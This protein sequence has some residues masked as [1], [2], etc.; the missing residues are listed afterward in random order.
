MQSLDRI[1]DNLDHVLHAS[2]AD[3]TEVVWLETRRRSAST[4]EG[5]VPDFPEPPQ[6]CA[7]VRVV[8]GSREGQY[9]CGHYRTDSAHPNDLDDAVRQALAQARSTPPEEDFQPPSKDPQ[10]SLELKDLFDPRLAELEPAEGQER[11]QQLIQDSEELTFHWGEAHLAIAHSTG[12]RRKLRLTAAEL[13]VIHG[14]GPGA[15]IARSAARTLEA[16]DALQVVERSHQRSSTPAAVRSPESPVLLAPEA[17]AS[18][19]A[20]L[21]QELFRHSSTAGVS[22]T[23]EPPSGAAPGAPSE[24]FRWSPRLEIY[25]D[26]TETTGLPVP[27]DFTGRPKGRVD[28][29]RDGRWQ[30]PSEESALAIGGGEQQASNLFMAAGDSS[31]QELLEAAGGGLWISD[32]DGL[33][34]LDPRRLRFVA[35]ARGLRAIAGGRLGAALPDQPWQLDLGRALGQL[36]A[37]GRERICLATGDG[38]LSSSCAPAL[39]YR[40]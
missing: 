28:L 13:S 34:C 30:T 18:I 4:A 37:V 16:L 26:G 24:P 31:P 36:V 19:L 32:F 23:E 11:L 8:E 40:P 39:V 5:S 6:R 35:R 1:L 22:P 21:V 14:E 15:G 27:F 3:F 9:R 12:L 20:V 7:L 29:I 2:P 10:A 17:T 33:V 25:D 38:L